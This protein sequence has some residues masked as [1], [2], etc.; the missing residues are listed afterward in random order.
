MA[1]NALTC[2][3]LSLVHHLGWERDLAMQVSG[4]LIAG[5]W[6]IL[7]VLTCEVFGRGVRQVGR[8]VFLT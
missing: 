7:W 6:N 4:F 2:F 8:D 5:S 1:L 3:S